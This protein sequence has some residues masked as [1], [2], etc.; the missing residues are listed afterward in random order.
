[1]SFSP[2]T[3]TLGDLIEA[4][5][6]ADR[7]RVVPRGFATPHS[8]RGYYEDLGFEPAE[9]VTVCEMLA[10]AQAALGATFCG[11]KGGDYVMGED[12]LCWLANWGDTGEPI[13]A[14]LVAYMTGAA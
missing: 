12:T 13:T 14:T 6:R 11:Y 4:L 9:N 2:G 5:E 1:M 8:Y 3:I 10:N 7:S